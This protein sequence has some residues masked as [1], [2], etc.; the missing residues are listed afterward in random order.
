MVG[1]IEEEKKEKEREWKGMGGR[2][3][4]E[5]SMSVCW[6]LGIEGGV[7]ALSDRFSEKENKY[8]KKENKNKQKQ[9]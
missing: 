2:G 4:R 7:G 5:W 6:V 9:P 3:G 8:I 1:S